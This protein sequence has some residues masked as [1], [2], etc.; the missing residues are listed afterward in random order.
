M[1]LTIPIKIIDK[2]LLEPEFE[3]RYSTP[4]SS[5]FDLRA[6]IDSTVRMYPGDELKFPL[7]FASQ[8]PESISCLIIPRSGLGSLGLIIS[9]GTGLIDC[10]YRG[11]W[12]MSASNRGKTAIEVMPMMRVAQCVIVPRLQARLVPVAELT[13]TARGEGGF[14]STGAA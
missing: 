10:D 6:C 7:G 9:N 14:G 13:H 12:Q 3:M 8:I 1:L 2:R 5:A 4:G 11:E